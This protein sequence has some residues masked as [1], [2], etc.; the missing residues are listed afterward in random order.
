MKTITILARRWFDKTWGNTYHSV[1]VLVDGV[2]IG[3]EPFQ[4]GYGE[5]YLQTAHALLQKN[6]SSIDW[7]KFQDNM[8]NNRNKFV[9]DCCDVGRRKD[10]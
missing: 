3:Y 6:G 5:C 4:Y 8:R 7:S 2:E 1:R 9:I 10:L